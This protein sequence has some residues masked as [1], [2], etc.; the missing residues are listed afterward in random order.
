MKPSPCFCWI[1]KNQIESISK[2]D[3][4]HWTQAVLFLKVISTQFSIWNETKSV[5]LCWIPKNQ[6][7][8]I[9]ISGCFHQT[10][11][12]FSPQVSSSQRQAVREILTDIT[13]PIVCRRLGEIFSH[14]FVFLFAFL[15]AAI[16]QYVFQYVPS[17]R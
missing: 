10:E 1:P 3:Y 15:D 6:A 9:P 8:N 11:G 13:Q 17:T 4:F 5:F 7:E 12:D 14:R 16:S 2:S